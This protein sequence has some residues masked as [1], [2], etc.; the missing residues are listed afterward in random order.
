MYDPLLH[1]LVQKLMKKNFYL[2]LYELKQLGCSVIH[3]NF[4]R[5]FVKTKKRD[6]EEAITHI[7]FVVK[8]IN[9]N[10]MFKFISLNAQEFWKILLFK[11]Y[12]NYAGIKESNPD[13]VDF[14]YDVSLH[15]PEAVQHKFKLT[16]CE[17]ILKVHQFNQ[18]H[19]SELY[20]RDDD[21]D[22]EIEK[23]KDVMDTAED[24]EK[25]KDHAFISNLIS[26][27]FCRKLLQ[28]VDRFINYKLNV[29]QTDVS[30]GDDELRDSDE[31]EERAIAKQRRLEELAKWEF[32]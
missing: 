22:I 26:D 2:L 21:A 18:K 29:E 28:L 10:P 14:K 17:F 4:H 31:V 6:L 16:I 3:G 24:F 19:K 5:I 20:L 7:N 25:E 11:D 23:I 1:R 12:Y 32:P 27:Y 13:V 8:T 9:E 15:L 30:D